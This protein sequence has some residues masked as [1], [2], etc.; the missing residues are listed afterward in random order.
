MFRKSVLLFNLDDKRVLFFLNLLNKKTI[1]EVTGM[2]TTQIFEQIKV[3]IRPW[4]QSKFLP[5]W[6]PYID[7]R[8]TESADAPS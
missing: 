8:R 5:E 2:K 7:E 4:G 1:L 3:P 6:D